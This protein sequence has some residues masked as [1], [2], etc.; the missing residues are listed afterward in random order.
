MI[1]VKN[2]NKI[3]YLFHKYDLNISDKN[4]EIPYDCL[5]HSIFDN[6]Y[7]CHYHIYDLDKYNADEYE[8]IIRLINYFNVVV[9]FCKGNY[10]K[11]IDYNV[12]LIRIKNVG[13]DIGGKLTA[14]EYLKRNKVIYSYILFLHSKSNYECRQ[15]YFHPFIQNEYRIKL[16]KQLIKEKNLYG[17]FPNCI[18]SPENNPISYDVFYSNEKYYD[19]ILNY[20]NIPKYKVFAEGN[21]FMCKK[22]LVD[23]IFG[24]DYKLFYNLLNYDN[25]FDVN[26]FQ[27]YYKTHHLTIRQNYNKYKN[28]KLFGNNILLHNNP[29]KSLPDGMIEHIFERIWITVINGMNKKYLVLDKEQCIPYYN[30]KINA[31]YFPQFHEI[32]END[33][34]WG[35]NFTEWTLLKP[36]KKEQV[37][38]NKNILIQKP[39]ND[40][41][42]YNLH[43]KD[44]LLNQISI[45]NSYNING[46]IIYHYWFK[47]NHKV[48]YKPLEYFL[49]N[50]ITFPFCI[51][52]AN[53]TWSNRWDGSSNGILIKQEYSKNEKDFITHIQY[54]IQFFKMPNYMKNER[55]ECIFYIYKFN[56]LIEN[57][58][59]TMMK[60]WNIELSKHNL[61]ICVIITENSFKETHNID[62]IHR[63]FLFEPMYS[64]VYRKQMNINIQNEL[65]SD[66]FVEKF[67]IEYYKKMNNDLQMMSTEQLLTH[68][69]TYG[70]KE[71]RNYKYDGKIINNENICVNYD[72]IIYNYNNEVYDLTNKHL[73]LPLYWNNMVRRKNKAFLYVDNFDI[74]KLEELFIILI[75]KIIMRSCN[76]Y[77]LD[78]INKNDNVININAWNEWNEQAV[79]EPNDV[80]GYDNLKTI[81]NVISHI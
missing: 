59:N 72:E 37:V 11:I 48:L 60:Y 9:T 32:P 18:F 66:T 46:F 52:W 4:K 30:I 7:I 39:H 33:H 55:G 75:S 44:V 3:K 6:H 31:I 29:E 67:D 26:W 73:G 68:F 13:Y 38:N 56:E 79:L 21:V 22:Q 16:I 20:L 15:L 63:K 23:Y 61:K 40:I 28:E 17:I 24:N 49:D 70:N 51:S 53:E 71:N 35:K 64:C 45:A 80:T 69:I 42:Y 41:G 50:N 65:L 8:E 1:E 36:Y 12:S 81:S 74:T 5:K 34:F 27:T 58:Y 25:S 76:I 43:N 78:Y 19:D 2:H 57:N 10:S 77:N 14:L 62:N 47:N 54:L